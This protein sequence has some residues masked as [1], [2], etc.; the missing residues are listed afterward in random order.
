[1]SEKEQNIREDS[2][3]YHRRSPPGKIAL[4]PTKQLTNQR[5]LALAYS[6]GVAA[7]CDEIV[8]DPRQVSALTA[9]GNLVGVVTNGTAVLGLGNIGPLAA[10][11]VMEGKAVLFKKFAGL[12]CYDIELAENDPDKLVDMICALEPTFGGINLEDIKAPEC[13][14]IERKC[15]E[16]MKIPV[17]HDDQHGTAI[18]V[19]A[20]V[21]NGLRVVGKPFA[22]VKLVCSGAG[23]AALACLDLLVNLGIR[24]ENIFVS[25][26][27]GVVYEGRTELMDDNKA[28]YAQPT[29]ARTLAE[30]MPGTDIFLGLSAGRVLKPEWLAKMAEKPL[31]LALANPEPEI[32]PDV[33]KAARPDAIIA[34]GRSDFP[35]Q[36]NNVLC[37]PFIFRGALDVGA[38]AINEA[39]KLASVRALADLAMI[40]QSDIVASAYNLQETLPFGP[41]YLIPKPFDPRLIVMIAPAVAKAAMESGVATRPI[42]DFD[43]Y[44]ARLTNFVWHSGLLMKPI[45]SAAKQAPKRIVFAEGE[46]ERVLRAV[47]VVV[48]EKLAQP[49]L[50]GRPAVLERRIERAG[51]RIRPN[52]DFEVI[53]PDQDDRFR[54][55]W[56][57]YYE[58]TQRKGVS[59]SYAQIEMRR[60]QTLIGAMMIHR[61]DADGMV[62]GTFGTYGLHLHYVDQVLGRRTGVGGYAAMNAVLLPSRTVFIADTYVNPDP[63]AEQIAEIAVLCADEIRRFGLTP[64]IALLSH[65]SFGT[66]DYPSARKMREALALLHHRAPELEAEGEMHGDAALSETVRRAAF[67]N[68]RLEGD[69]N[70]LIMPTLDAA[71]ISF[72]LLKVASGGG[73]TMGPILLGCAKPVHI[74]TPSATVRRIVNMT[75]LT[76]VDCAI[77]RQ[78]QLPY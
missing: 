13:F 54:D 41:D 47:Q 34:T 3:A 10:K 71:N 70:L 26:I 52:T 67:P 51:L 72:N 74:L 37:F 8:R 56:T 27:K 5:D 69:A 61:G 55:Y 7:A 57:N 12:D 38:T 53:N 20:A 40:E 64:K 66:S 50:V 36:V 2:L 24:R 15:R 22:D 1:M 42:E 39:M 73:V 65:S 9:R 4:L 6:P 16:R 32:M 63:T 33:A 60:R 77:E 17:F 19:G 23:A 14:Y 75:A 43:A 59:Q 30:L 68:S 28:R 25:D 48:D 76:V 11:P 45:F 78:A 49:I 35:N 62:C 44:R 58:L 46:D 31:I 29:A 18:I 21:L